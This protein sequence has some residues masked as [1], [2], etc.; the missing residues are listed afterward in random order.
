MSQDGNPAPVSYWRSPGNQSDFLDLFRRRCLSPTFRAEALV[1]AG[2]SENGESLG[3]R[4]GGQPFANVLTSLA[5]DL[6]RPEQREGRQ[7]GSAGQ[8]GGLHREECRGKGMV[9]QGTQGHCLGCHHRDGPLTSAEA[10]GL[11]G[12]WV[13]PLGSDVHRTR[14]KPQPT[15]GV[16]VLLPKGE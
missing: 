5:T 1:L 6:L 8:Q 16:S 4:K 10:R 15:L 3:R 12:L 11:W 7:A 14:A 13:E 9:S 2:G